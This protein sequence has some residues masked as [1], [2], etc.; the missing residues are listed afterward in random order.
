VAPPVFL[1]RFDSWTGA[2][3]AEESAHEFC[4]PA[5]GSESGVVKQRTRA[6]LANKLGWISAYKATK[7]AAGSYDPASQIPFRDRYGEARSKFPLGIQP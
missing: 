3:F 4:E 6:V 2:Q 5:G 1:P 7:G